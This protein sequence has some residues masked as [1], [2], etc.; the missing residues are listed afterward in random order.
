MKRRRR[1]EEDKKDLKN[2]IHQG[3]GLIF[4]LA[5]RVVDEIKKWKKRCGTYPPRSALLSAAGAAS[6][7]DVLFAHSGASAHRSTQNLER[8]A[9][10]FSTRS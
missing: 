4:K 2:K 10:A 9:G 6:P 5:C 3:L 7:G 8:S 1:R